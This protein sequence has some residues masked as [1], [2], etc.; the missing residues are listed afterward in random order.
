MMAVNYDRLPEELRWNRQ[1]L[2]AGP[3]SDGKY[4]APFTFNRAGHIHNASP[5]DPKHWV[6][7]ETAVEATQVFKPYGLGF[8][9]TRTDNFTCIDLDIKNKHNEPDETKHTKVEDIRRF[10][11]IIEAFDSYTE[12]S[13][14]GQGYHIW[15]RGKVGAGLKRDGV[16]LYSQDRFIVCT[17]D[18]YLDRE[19][20]RNQDMLDALVFEIREQQNEQNAK[21]ELQELPQLEED[22]SIWER[23][24]SAD[25]YDKFITLC[26]GNWDG[27]PS[28]SE[29]DLALMSIFTFY[30]QSNEQCRR[31]FRQT[32]LGQRAKATKNDIALN[33]I[34]QVIRG[35]QANEATVTDAAV[36]SAAALVSKLQ[37]SSASAANSAPHTNTPPQQTNAIAPLNYQYDD[38]PTPEELRGPIAT[39]DP[40]YVYEE[41]RIGDVLDWPPGFVGQIAQ[42]IFY[43]SPRPVREVAIVSALGL[44][45]GIQGKAWNIPQSGLNLYIV[46]V[47]QSAI[48]KEAMHSGISLILSQLADSCPEALKYVDFTD[49]A[50]GP[51]LTKGSALNPS[52]VNVAGEW[53]RKLTRL[54]ADG[55]ADAAMQTLRTTMTNF[56]QKSGH[57][58]MVGGLGYSDKEKNVA[59]TSGIAYSMIG[60]STPGAFY[61]S[62][63][64]TM[65][66]DGFLSRFTIIEYRGQ[67]PPANEKTVIKLTPEELG[68][69]TDIV[70]TADKIIAARDVV[71]VNK[72]EQAKAFL[73][74]FDLKCD[75]EINKT[76]DESWRQMWNRAH[77]KVCRIAANLAVAENFTNP[78]INLEQ[79]QWA[80]DVIL[81][82]IAIMRSRIAAGEVGTSDASR[83]RKLLDLIKMYLSKPIPEGYGIDDAMRKKGI[84]P[85]KYLQISTQRST[86]FTKQ[87]NGQNSALDI[88]IKSLMDSGYL[89]E[90]AKATAA[91]D[92]NFHGRCFRVVS[93]PP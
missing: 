14:S 89:V 31:M 22:A 60:E 27:Y 4:K 6:D 24:K 66:E 15:V 78:V 80:L 39:V 77:L 52:F 44:F 86:N 1:W 7:Y 32:K 54:S 72:N 9:L 68:R 42:Y 43:N 65:M 90:V 57:N 13:A 33:R 47:A 69:F 46:L 91:T 48:G 40:D 23:A 36:A 75:A 64:E 53:G 49:Y 10:H 85:R 50:S 34:L 21:A 29:A 81:R 88:T 25:N 26:S 3:S 67:R 59:T 16:E 71:I 84:V 92:Y 82:D 93:L 51:A 37:T 12:R 5:V 55:G 19:I 45:A 8:V 20:K 74:A 2:L 56:Y 62:L 61:D 35:R 38:I 79:S 17:G 83:E 87:R 11:K 28:Q 73:N 41:K 63:N 58:N 18:V 76:M 70:Q 30:T